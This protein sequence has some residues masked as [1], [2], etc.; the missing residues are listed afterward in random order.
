MIL[1]SDYLSSLTRGKN[2]LYK[3]RD[4]FVV[5][6]FRSMS[7]SLAEPSQC[8]CILLQFP[9]YFISNS[10]WKTII[11]HNCRIKVLLYFIK[12]SL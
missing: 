8:N 7:S 5:N 2:C 9:K 6:C 3:A 11:D 10:S 4:F 1:K 12:A